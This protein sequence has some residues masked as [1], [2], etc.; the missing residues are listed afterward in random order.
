MYNL[1]DEVERQWIKGVLNFKDLEV[2]DV[3]RSRIDIVAINSQ[4][5]F[6]EVLRIM[7]SAGY[8]RFPVFND[9]LDNIIGTIYLKDIVA[10][11]HANRE[12]WKEK[13]REPFFVPENLKL[14]KLLVSFQQKK[15]HMAVVVDEYGGTSGLVTLEDILEEIVGEINDEHDEESDQI[16]AKKIDDSTYVFDAKIPIHDFLKV[17]GFSEDFL[18][19]MDE[20]V[21]TLAGIL[22]L[23]NGD[24]PKKN[25]T[26]PFKNVTFVILKMFD[27][28]IGIVKMIIHEKTEIAK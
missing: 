10:L 13:I 18:D 25:Q 26:I 8:S 14:S 7:L 5:S 11:L 16:L 20:E 1:D 6:T 27:Y 19:G 21:E 9:N 12:D 2:S 15:I 3:M 24:F 23:I 4:W 22:L 17:T 28:R